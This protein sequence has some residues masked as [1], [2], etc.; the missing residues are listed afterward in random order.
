MK[1][2]GLEVLA[3]FARTHAEVRTQ[4]QVWLAEAEEAQWKGADDIQRRYPTASFLADNRVVFN[5]KGRK[6]RM[7]VKVSYRLQIVMIDRV[8]TH[9][10]YSKWV[11]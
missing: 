7:V 1:V 8:G 2:L 5:V 9:A 3:E 11:L 4:L 10:E 6:Y